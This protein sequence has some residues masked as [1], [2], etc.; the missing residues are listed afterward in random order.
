MILPKTTN[1]YNHLIDFHNGI[2]TFPPEDTAPVYDTTQIQTKIPQPTPTS[3]EPTR[4]SVSHSP[5]LTTLH[6]KK[7]GH[8]SEINSTPS[9][10]LSL[11]TM[12]MPTSKWHPG[13]IL[14]VYIM[15]L[16]T[17]QYCHLERM[18]MHM[19]HANPTSKEIGLPGCKQDR[20]STS[21]STCS[22]RTLLPVKIYHTLLKNAVMD[23]QI[24]G[25]Q[26]AHHMPWT[27]L[28]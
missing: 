7:S 5:S 18:R 12:S 27:L 3:E 11:T 19:K 28:L 17:S 14:L 2:S 21:E 23:S 1:V 15:R 9:L 25:S 10:S 20:R 26:Y 8:R 13:D 6:L 24:N 16:T 4:D 22:T